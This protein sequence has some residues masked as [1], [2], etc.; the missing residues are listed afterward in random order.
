[1]YIM[2]IRERAWDT[3]HAI[4]TADGYLGTYLSC[5]LR[6]LKFNSGVRTYLPASDV[7]L[8]LENCLGIL[9]SGFVFWEY[10]AMDGS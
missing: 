3:T 6:H 8:G 2:L 4:E 1:M 9:V 10:C 7:S 5:D